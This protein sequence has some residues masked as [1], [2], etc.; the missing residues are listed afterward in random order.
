[1]APF[2]VTKCRQELLERTVFGGSSTSNKMWPYRHQ[3]YITQ[4]CFLPELVILLTK[5]SQIQAV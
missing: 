1:M 5:K 2:N 3:G 4:A